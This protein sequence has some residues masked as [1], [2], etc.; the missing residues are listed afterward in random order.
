MGTLYSLVNKMDNSS[1][2]FSKVKHFAPLGGTMFA[3]D[4]AGNILKE[5]NPGQYDFTIDHTAPST[6]GA[7]FLADQQGRIV[8]AGNDYLGLYNGGYDDS[9]KVG[10]TSWQHPMDTY[11][12]MIV[13][14]NK[15]SVGLID[16]Q[17][18]DS[19]NLA[20]LTFPND[21]TVDALKSGPTGVLFGVNLG[22]RAAIVL[23]DTITPRSATAWKWVK[24]NI[25][26]IELDGQQWV[27]RT[28]REILVTNG[29]T[30]RHAFGTL[31]DPLSFRNY[32]N[33][34]TLPQQMSLVNDSLLFAITRQTTT[35]SFEYARMKPGLYLYGMKTGA[36]NFLP[37]PTQ[38][39]ITVDVYAVFADAQYSNRILVSYYDAQLGRSYIAA[40]VP[41]AAPRAVLISEPLGL[42]HPHYQ[43]V[44]FGPSDKI[45]E[46]V[47]L[48]FTPLTTSV[49]PPTLSFN[50][51]V[52]VYDFKRPLWGSAVTHQLCP[53]N[54]LIIDGTDA[55]RSQSSAGQVQVGDEVTILNGVNAGFVAHITQIQNQGTTSE[56]WTLDDST[57]VGTESGVLLNVQPFRKIGK[58]SFT[59]LAQLKNLY[60][61]TGQS[62]RGKQFLVKVVIDG[63]GANFQLEMQ[64]GYFVFDDIGYDQT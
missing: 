4:D 22:N 1:V 14:G 30:V 40:L 23:W 25:L 34:D 55:T 57:S 11:E 44:Y 54:Q 48:N 62:P 50:V 12:N 64:T 61:N 21:M 56:A 45:A 24:G 5:Q 31:D 47:V 15:N 13:F 37:M 38:N 35:Q 39:T 29:Y 7:G 53:T 63:L 3:Y 43:R 33:P 19:T 27:V 9:W 52:K 6:N 51:S 17:A 32:A 10:L 46:A 59:S 8:Y 2:L 26:S 36:W 16:T 20:A 18:G 58:K 28:T 49:I 60:F 41:E 42:G